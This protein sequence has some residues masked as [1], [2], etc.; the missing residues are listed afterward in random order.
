MNIDEVTEYCKKFGYE[1]GYN[2]GCNVTEIPERSYKEYTCL[3][4]TKP[5]NE[6]MIIYRVGKILNCQFYT[7][8][9][10]KYIIIKDRFTTTKKP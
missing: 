4:L 5:K 2:T 6:R 7:E 10:V 3:L 8:S 9:D 1:S